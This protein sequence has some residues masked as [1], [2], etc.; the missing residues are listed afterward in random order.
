MKDQAKTKNEL[1]RE[2]VEL[3]QEYN[4]LK[5][6]VNQENNR[7]INIILSGSGKSGVQLA[8]DL[9]PDLIL[10]DLDLPD[11]HGSE[12]FEILQLDPATSTIPV[13]STACSIHSNRISSS[14][15]C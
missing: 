14:L 8:T 10:L 11:L 15:I 4:A 13:T 2:I 5:E 1:I 6:A 12:V 3:R 7:A 9:K